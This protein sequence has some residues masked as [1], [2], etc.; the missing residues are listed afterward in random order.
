M[1]SFTAT[2][3]LLAASLAIIPSSLSWAG[4][5]LTF[6][7]AGIFAGQSID[8]SYGDRVVASP[9]GNGHSYQLVADGFGNALYRSAKSTGGP[10]II[11]SLWAHSM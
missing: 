7:Q 8:Q 5:V 6:D 4:V 11:S 10:S 9:D 2:G 3:F 1:K